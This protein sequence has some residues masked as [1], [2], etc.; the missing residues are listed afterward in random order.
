MEKLIT[1][2]TFMKM[3]SGRMHTPHLT[4]LDPPL[5]ISYRHHQKSLA[6][7]S[8]L[9]SLIGYFFTKRQSQKGGHGTMVPLNTLLGKK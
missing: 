7:F 2:K 3:A 1:S 6:H 4:S 5:A 8:H 9:A